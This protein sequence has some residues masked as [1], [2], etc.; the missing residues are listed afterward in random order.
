M[1]YKI[2]NSITFFCIVDDLRVII[3]KMRKH[4]IA[5]QWK[6]FGL[7]LGISS[8]DLNYIETVYRGDED[9]ILF[10]ILRVWIQR[11]GSIEPTWANLVE[12][13]DDIDA[14]RAAEE[15]RGSKLYSSTI[16]DPICENHVHN[17]EAW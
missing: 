12:A 15:I 8:S 1:L 7:F 3:D 6:E 10:Y 5:T 17:C 11:N 14:R 4:H 13:L 9:I 16:N 2:I